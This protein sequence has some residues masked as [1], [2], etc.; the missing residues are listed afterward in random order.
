MLLLSFALNTIAHA[1]H[2]HDVAPTTAGHSLVCAH[3]LFF[4][5]LTDTPQP[6]QLHVCVRVAGT[7][8]VDAGVPVVPTRPVLAFRSRGPPV[9]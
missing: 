2:T 9:S 5:S 7:A 1:A 4:G 8:I 6:A 3:C